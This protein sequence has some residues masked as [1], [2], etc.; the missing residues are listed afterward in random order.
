[1]QSQQGVMIW[2][3]GGWGL[4]MEGRNLSGM[5]R[6]QRGCVLSLREEKEPAEWWAWGQYGEQRSQQVQQEASGDSLMTYWR[7]WNTRWGW[8]GWK[9]PYCG[10]L[11][12]KWY[13]SVSVLFNSDDKPRQIINFPPGS[14]VI[15]GLR[16]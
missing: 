2:S 10:E 12:S 5:G 11:C 1:M 6:K 14:H 7:Y 9:A 8:R 4:L 3:I 16:R 13:S 15:K